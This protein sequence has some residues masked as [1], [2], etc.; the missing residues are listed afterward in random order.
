MA[1]SAY[2]CRCVLLWGRVKVT[3]GG[4]LSK[5]VFAANYSVTSICAASHFNSDRSVC[6][7]L[8][9]PPAIRQPQVCMRAC[10]G[11]DNFVLLLWLLSGEVGVLCS[12]LVGI[13]LLAVV[14]GKGHKAWSPN[15]SALRASS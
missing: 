9:I 8:N 10:R 11:T 7:C 1:L 12:T 14:L 4:E 13:G 3:A 5:L 2:H 15:S 6:E